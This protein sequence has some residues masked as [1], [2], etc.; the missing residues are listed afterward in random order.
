[1]IVAGACL[2]VLLLA[3]CIRVAAKDP[4]LDSDALRRVQLDADRQ[5]REELLPLE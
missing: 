3:V 4:P 2:A 1:V 5:R